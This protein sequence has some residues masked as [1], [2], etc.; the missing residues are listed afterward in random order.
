MISPEGGKTWLVGGSLAASVT[1][2]Q[3]M[4]A[5][6]CSGDA[7]RSSA[8]V[9]EVLIELTRA[10]YHRR[11]FEVREPSFLGEG[12]SSITNPSSGPLP[13]GPMVRSDFIARI[14]QNEAGEIALRTSGS[15]GDAAVVTHSLANLTRAV[16]VNK[17]H[18]ED[19]WG[20]AFNPSH[21]A[22][23]QVFLQA[24]ANGN[25]MVNLWGMDPPDAVARCKAWEVTH[26]SATPTF[27]RLMTALTEPL[28][29]VRSVS[30]GGEA[31]DE[32]LLSRLRETF[33]N[34]RLH[35]V[36]ASTEAGTLLTADGLEFS[37]GE[38]DATRIRIMDDRIWVHRSAL[39]AFDGVVEWFDTGDVVEIT[40]REP[41]RFRIV[42]R[43]RNL[44]NVGGE[45]VNPHEVEVALRQHPGI[46]A[47]R[48]F[49]R[50]NSVTGELLAAEV[51][52]GIPRLEE[53]ELRA[54]LARH[55][56]VYKIPRIL[57]FVEQ[58]ELTR[59]GKLRRN[60]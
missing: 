35:N 42:G 52:S 39:G 34:A 41:L 56:P 9:A 47:A 12:V 4:D 46:V 7:R 22:G 51:V 54:Y 37:L 5:V 21:I 23:V 48:V 49:G 20:L 31:A 15:T 1:Y 53:T 58:L 57:R 25:T 8:S 38:K 26:L 59:T 44:V 17:R 16:V 28:L 24:L 6:R 45:K 40:S 30:I 14:M 3:F 32:R 29:T 43:M 50:R 27:Y 10:L 55:L 13:E 60:D 11:T 19:V 36:Y 18:G 2:A 33:P